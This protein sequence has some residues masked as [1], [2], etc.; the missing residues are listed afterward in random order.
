MLRVV[1][2]SI[3]AMLGR[4]G[5]AGAGG[6]AKIGWDRDWVNGSGPS[7]YRDLLQLLWGSSVK[8]SALPLSRDW[9][10]T[11]SHHPT[12]NVNNVTIVYL[13]SFS[14]KTIWVKS[15]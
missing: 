7:G 4:S 10:L 9:I 6:L 8:T 12:K 14:V 5:R 1:S 2:R 3:P 13:L 15:V 11:T